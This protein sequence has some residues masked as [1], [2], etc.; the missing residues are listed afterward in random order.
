LY[1]V[2]TPD[3]I[4]VAVSD[5]YLQATMTYREA[6]LGRHIFEVFPDNPD[7][8]A[9]TGVRN[10]R[11]SLERVLQHGIAD[12]MAVQK[13]DIRR[14]ESEGGGFEERYWSPV[15]S[16]VFGADHAIMYIIHRVEDV[17]EFVRLKQQRRE[18]HQQTE[19]LRSRAEQ[20]E[21]EI[22][23]RAQEVQ[24]INQQLLAANH[25]LARREQERTQLYE[26]LKTLDRLKTQFFAN[27]SHE[28]RT[29]LTLILGPV[30]RL[31]AADALSEPQRHD[32]AVVE[33]NAQ[34]LLKHVNDLLDIAKLDAGMLGLNKQQIDLVQL[35]RRMA[36]HF[37]GLAQERRITFS[38]ETPPVVPAQVDP[39]KLHR[40]FLN[41]LANAFKFTP[42]GGV[43]RCIVEVTG[44]QATIAVEDSGPGVPPE[45]RTTIFERFRQGEGSMSRRFGGTGLG[46]A[47]A[48]EFIE[49]HGGTITVGD[50]RGAGARFQVELPLTTPAD[51]APPVLAV[52]TT[53]A[54]ESA[55]Q[56]LEELR[57]ID[58]AGARGPG[59]TGVAAAFHSV[60]PLP[61]TAPLVLVVENHP[62]MARFLAET[63]AIEYRV[64][65]AS[66]GQAGLERALTEPPDLILSD[67]M[68]PG[69]DGFALLRALRADVR[70]ASVP[71]ILLSARAD[72]EAT[73]EGLDAGAD[74]YLVKPFSARELR[75]RMRAN[76]ELADLRRHMNEEQARRVAAETAVRERDQFLTLA[77]HELK[78]PLTSLQGFAE[79]LERRGR[80]DSR[81]QARDQRALCVIVNQARRLN[82]LVASLLDLSLIDSTRFSMQQAPVDLGALVQQTAA[83][84]QLTLERYTLTWTV[85]ATPLVVLGDALRLEQVVHQLLQNAIKYSPAGTPIYVQVEQRG[86]SACIEVSDQGIG[87]PA[88]ARTSLFQRFYRA[89]NVDPEQISGL[90]IGLFVVHEIVIRHGGT[91][92]VQSSEGQGST[93]T[94]CL[95][96]K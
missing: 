96:A 62:E 10:L 4:I 28:L 58:A 88:S 65:T 47:I 56:V 45:L 93:F 81:F 94:V 74:D 49:L 44:T 46:L 79:L 19:A 15:N 34:T 31:L 78:T 50:A 89:E 60:A 33:R 54:G 17:T 16:P 20:M 8:P 9:A 75:A 38:V 1:L 36:A 32:L 14:P 92:A 23:L 35:I 91:I 18:Q 86:A 22:Y 3:F 24:R 21:M 39:E 67:V 57:Q 63:L 84:T 69:M 61:P 2:L 6:I 95:P 59:S 71:I 11:A 29:P 66:N 68:M 90:G 7:D 5:A 26:Q 25:E 87:I 80:L 12:T 43:V 72:E 48:K 64:A 85:P 73:V 52:E 37:D 13:Y 27:I 82:T 70:T 41:L 77:A 30:R 40:S 42:N 55:R 76:L 83:E 53:T 51:A